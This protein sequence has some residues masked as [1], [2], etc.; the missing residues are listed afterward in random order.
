M[1]PSSDIINRDSSEA[2]GGVDLGFLSMIGSTLNLSSRHQTDADFTVDPEGGGP[3]ADGDEFANDEDATSSNRGKKSRTTGV[4]KGLCLLGVAAA[5]VGVAVP[6]KNKAAATNANFAKTPKSAKSGKCSKEVDGGGWK[7]VRHVPAKWD[8]DNNGV[9]IPAWHPATDSLAG[10]DTYG[11]DAN[12]KPESDDTPWSLEFANAVPTWGD[13]NDEFLFA[14]GD[15]KKWVVATKD[16]VIG[17]NYNL[18]GRTIKLSSTNKNTYVAKWYNR[19]AKP[20][21]PWVS[22]TGHSQSI[23]PCL[24]LYGENGEKGNACAIEQNDGADVYIRK[25]TP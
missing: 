7:K 13:N 11:L 14:T 22:I 3:E 16:A 18:D 17:E 10:T 20:E 4:I 6:H 5:I 12:G 9:D 15:C 8:V 1:S 24:I 23:V 19:A 2:A 21:D 25:A